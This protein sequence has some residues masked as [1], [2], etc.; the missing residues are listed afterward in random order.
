M[1]NQNQ[2]TSPQSR[3]WQ[4]R[5]I[6]GFFL[7][8]ILILG[9][10]Q[11]LRFAVNHAVYERQVQFEDH[12]AKAVLEDLRNQ[13]KTELAKATQPFR[14]IHPLDDD[15][16]NW[17]NMF[18]QYFA[19]ALIF[20]VNGDGR[21]DIY[22]PQDG[23]NWTRPSDE[24]KVLEDKPRFQHNGLYI[25]QG[26]ELDGTPIY[27]QLKELVK[28]NDTYVAEELLVEDYLYPRN[29]TSD[30]EDRYGRNSNMAVAADFN[31][32]GLVDLMVGNGLPTMI[33]SH[34]KTQRV[35]PQ[36][37]SPWGRQPIHSK[38]PLAAM[39]VHFLHDYKAKDN[40]HDLR[41]S[42]RGEEFMGA[43]SLYINTGDK[44]G[45]GLP[46]WRD[47]S[48]ETGLEGQR[49][50]I[51]LAVA[52]VDLDGDLDIY[53]GNSPDLDY[54]PGGAK[55]WA[56]A[57]N[58]LYINM[59]AETGEL[60]FEERASKMDVDEVFD[61]DFEMP[62]FYRMRRISWLPDEY[63]IIFPKFEPY[64][65]NYLE[66]DGKE[67]EHGQIT[68]ATLFQDVNEDGYPDLWIANDF[69]MLR[70]Y[71]NQEGK[72]FRRE[73]H[74]RNK[75]TGNWM[76][77][78][79]GDFNG[80]SKEDVFCGN[81][82]GAA[83]NIAVTVPDP[84]EMFEPGIVAGTTF[85]QFLGDDEYN[86]RHDFKHAIIDGSNPTQEFDIA[87]THSRVLPPDASLDNNIR[88]LA[89]DSMLRLP[90]FDT[91]SLD[92]YE[93]TWGSTAFDVQNDG[94]TDLYWIGG[95]YGRGGGIFPVVGTSPG[96]LM[97][98]ATTD[99]SGVAFEDLTAE[100]Q[101]FNIEEIQY[102][103]LESDGYIYRKAPRQNWGKR[104]MVYSYDRST[105]TAQGPQIQERVT[106]SDMIQAA[107]QARGV[108]T[109]D[110]N[111]DGFAD[112][113]VRNVGGYDSRS[114]RAGNLKAMIDGKPRVLPAHDYNYPNLTNYE[115]GNTRI[116]LNSYK[117]NNWVKVHLIDDAADT[118]NRDAI[119]ATIVVNDGQE[120]TRRAWQ[121]G[122]VATTFENPIFG[123]GEAKA[124]MVEIHW[125]DKQRTVSRIAIDNLANGTLT[126]SK[127]KG[128]VQWAPHHRQTRVA[129]Q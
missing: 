84:R 39:G 122:F 37:T 83:M 35:L 67:A 90:P 103:R 43:N 99:E 58:Q 56:G 9:G 7:F 66:I 91:N 48:R 74:A 17:S 111:G 6:N 112:M 16:H 79:A 93:F 104:D 70:L 62:Y 18:S 126:I 107:E 113:I 32:D 30:S 55:E 10:D 81:L 8:I 13:P 101:V 116:F 38:L 5:L 127:T 4:R 123:L 124:Q 121:G 88:H 22:L 92:P 85:S 29:N 34:E 11:L 75:A 109:G 97:I 73:D 68:W 117:R 31:N 78:A 21:L 86:N 128:L 36:M 94:L 129:A 60:R 53:E 119:G 114:S 3:P 41:E 15:A 63:S 106:N 12:S 19:G 26:N 61:E 1:K 102:D 110:L 100:H 95:L 24:N 82:G 50:T 120:K 72:S 2:V 33:W 115:R 27:K 87:V 28:A 23:Q 64:R 98:N 46:E 77:L 14:E 44:D 89:P 49:N 40:T 57:A 65:P 47:A 69:G 54:W 59:L 108:T 25:N 105:W 76:S 42:A 45:D 20:D 52:D 80:D 118:F 71:V 96:R 51:S 125:P